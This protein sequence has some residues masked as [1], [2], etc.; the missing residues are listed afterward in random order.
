MSS[1]SKTQT[2]VKFDDPTIS[3]LCNVFNKSPNE[4]PRLKELVF[5]INSFQQDIISSLVEA[6][7]STNT[8]HFGNA[9]LR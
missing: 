6:I 9:T 2:I 5:P 1:K 7:P 3:T 8:F 4:V